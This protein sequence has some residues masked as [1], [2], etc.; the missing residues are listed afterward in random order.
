MITLT[1]GLLRKRSIYVY[2]F[3]PP[4]PV[5]VSVGSIA[6]VTRDMV[7]IASLTPLHFDSQEVLISPGSVLIEGKVKRQFCWD[8]AFVWPPNNAE[9]IV[10][11]VESGRY[12]L[13]LERITEPPNVVKAYRSAISQGLIRLETILNIETAVSSRPTLVGVVE[14]RAVGKGK[15]FWRYPRPCLAGQYINEVLSKLG[16]RVI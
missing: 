10:N 5:S 11:L 14:L 8:R 12:A 3:R 6:L 13:I 16:V 4:A 1:T 15:P 7:L 9:S 2:G